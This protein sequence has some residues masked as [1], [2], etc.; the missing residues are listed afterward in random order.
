MEKSDVSPHVKKE[1]DRAEERFQKFLDS[2]PELQK[3]GLLQSGFL[4]EEFFE[5]PMT[6]TEKKLYSA[7]QKLPQESRDEVKKRIGIILEN[8]E[9]N[10]EY[11][12]NN[13]PPELRDPLLEVINEMA[14]A[15][16]NK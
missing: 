15:R 2:P 10:H 5:K 9:M 4:K 7:L 12:L 8:A 14:E 11:S 16:K 1:A 3:D 6:E 13:V